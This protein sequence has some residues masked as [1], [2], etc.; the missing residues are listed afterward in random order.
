M[1]LWIFEKLQ[2]PRSTQLGGDKTE[3][4]YGRLG[5]SMK[6]SY[7]EKFISNKMSGLNG[8]RAEFHLDMAVDISISSDRAH[9]RAMFLI[10]RLKNI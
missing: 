5:N 7:S 8:L 6:K 3:N 10:L 9:K 1:G 4:K 2:S